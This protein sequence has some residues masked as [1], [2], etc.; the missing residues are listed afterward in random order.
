MKKLFLLLAALPVFMLQSCDNDEKDDLTNGEK[1]GLSQTELEYTW[2]GGCDTLQT[3]GSDW[4]F[5]EITV[6]DKTETLT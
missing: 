6:D 4:Y 5:S 2:R 1:I 3:Q